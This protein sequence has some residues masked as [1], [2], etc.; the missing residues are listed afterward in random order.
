MWVRAKSDLQ[1]CNIGSL[2]VDDS[3]NDGGTSI[4]NKSLA[5]W[6]GGTIKVSTEL[7]KDILSDIFTMVIHPVFKD[8]QDDNAESAFVIESV[9]W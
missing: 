7:L 6:F 8:S 5:C 1:A 9:N 2:F 3:M 4:V